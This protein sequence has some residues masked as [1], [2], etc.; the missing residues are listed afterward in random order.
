MNSTCLFYKSPHPQHWK[1][2]LAPSEKERSNSWF[3]IGSYIYPSYTYNFSHGLSSVEGGATCTVEVN[4]VCSILNITLSTLHSI[5]LQYITGHYTKWTSSPSAN[6]KKTMWKVICVRWVD[7]RSNWESRIGP[8][9]FR[10]CY[11]VFSV[12]RVG[13]LVKQTSGIQ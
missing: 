11:T 4:F 3:S 1:D 13:R 8:F 7:I 10:W 9:L 12:L 5:T 6:S 2:C